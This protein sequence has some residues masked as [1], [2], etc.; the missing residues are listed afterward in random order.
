MRNGDKNAR[1]CKKGSKCEYFHPLICQDS[2]KHGL[3]T[4]SKC[5]MHH[6]QGTRNWN[7]TDDR[8]QES[9]QATVSSYTPGQQMHRTHGKQSYATVVQ[10]KQPMENNPSGHSENMQVNFLELKTLIQQ[11]QREMAEIK[12]IPW[13]EQISHHSKECTR[14]TPNLH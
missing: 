6:I 8:I 1:G 2:L 3:C 13:R 5:L 4:K 10:A 14:C 12:N 7:M 9:R 11:M